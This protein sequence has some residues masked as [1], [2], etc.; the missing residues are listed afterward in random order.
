M[1]LLS[2]VIKFDRLVVCEPIEI[3]SPTTTD[4]DAAT[5]EDMSP[6]EIVMATEEKVRQLLQKAEKKAK[7]IIDNAH[8]E[9]EELINHANGQAVIIEEEAYAKG[10][11][12]GH[13]AALSQ[14]ESSKEQLL[15]E[16][17]KQLAEA[18]EKKENYLK[19]TRDEIVRLAKAI[20]ERLLL[21]Q[22]TLNEETIVKTVNSIIDLANPSHQ[23]T[24]LIQI[25]PEDE[26]QFIQAYQ[27]HRLSWPQENLK[28]EVAT[29][30][31]K[32]N[33]KVIT[34]KGAFELDISLA[35][36]NL[37]DLI[38]GADIYE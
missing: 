38:K 4:E 18:L 8:K 16:A 9:A 11:Q 29:S 20:A 3:I 27:E 15:E 10:Y 19:D 26:M 17:Q 22:L 33:C 24:V 7:D 5:D 1:R 2:K 13:D 36:D 21:Q 6:D 30:I 12:E 25:S 37:V 31:K 32:G 28:Y 23:S 34:S 14:I 35:I